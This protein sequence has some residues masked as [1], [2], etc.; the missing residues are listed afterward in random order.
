MVAL[1]SHQAD[2]TP[3]SLLLEELTWPEVRDALAA[4]YSTVIVPCGAVEQHGPHVAMLSDTLQAR[5]V[6]RRV[7]ERM[8]NTLVAPAIPVGCSEHHMAFPGTLSIRRETL[9]ATYTDYCRSLARH[10]FRRIACFSGHGGDFAPLADMLPRL[11]GAAAPARVAAYADLRAYIGAWSAEV[12]A[13]GEDVAKVGGHA[14]LPES[15]VVM[16][17]RPDLVRPE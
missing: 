2:A 17:L 5:A 6:A 8:G 7:A 16:A 11:R 9:E 4:G 13:V 10:G 14:D 15:S 12:A 1:S 3:P